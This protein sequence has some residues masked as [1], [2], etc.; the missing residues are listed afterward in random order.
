M[1]VDIAKRVKEV[2]VEFLNNKEGWN[3]I[4]TTIKKLQEALVCLQVLERQSSKLETL[5]AQFKRL[6]KSKVGR[7]N[8]WA[9]TK[10]NEIHSLQDVIMQDNIENHTKF[11]RPI[12]GLQ[13]WKRKMLWFEPLYERPIL[14]LKNIN[15][16]K[17]HIPN[18]PLS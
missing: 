15:A 1:Q 11:I 2:K 8:Y 6:K 16:L 10:L 9:S 7:I 5:K 12:Q 14:L 13:D 3:R 17:R 4:V 18:R